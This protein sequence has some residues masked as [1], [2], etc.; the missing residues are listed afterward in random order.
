MKQID[1]TFKEI[2][3]K[4]DT[5]QFNEAVCLFDTGLPENQILF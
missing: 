4:I 2:Q 3:H 1:L 5:E